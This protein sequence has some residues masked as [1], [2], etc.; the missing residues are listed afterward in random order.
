MQ[1]SS[2]MGERQ[3]GD[4]WLLVLLPGDKI[5]Y[6]Y[7]LSLVAAYFI[8]KISMLHYIVF[9]WIEVYTH[10]HRCGQV[11]SGVVFQN[12][13]T[14][15]LLIVSEPPGPPLIHLN[16]DFLPNQTEVVLTAS[17]P[18]TLSCHGNG[19]VRW[20]STAF[21]LMYEENLQ[22]LV[23]VPR[24][25]PKHTGTYR[26]GYSNQ[27][28]EHLYTWIH[29]YVKGKI[30]WSHAPCRSQT[31]EFSFLKMTLISNFPFAQIL[32]APTAF[33][34]HLA[35]PLMSRKTRTSYSGVCLPTRQSLTSPSNQRAAMGEGGGA[36]PGAWMWLLTP[37]EGPWS[38]T[39]RGHSTD[40][41]FVQAGRMDSSSN[42]KL[43]TCV[44]SPV[45]PV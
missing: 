34:S 37:K 2:N 41:T 39:C 24:S 19:S 44:W 10:Y 42:P 30:S 29:L 16:S 22:D 7:Y 12:Y 8:N 6:R 11:W 5:V 9:V 21:N 25:N 36:Y 33:S 3:P 20:S 23:Q 14:N 13:Q 26:C 43:S 17:T 27:S 38:E 15:L 32:L 1:N 18:F 31:D 40:A 28:L 4:N 45:R 35:D